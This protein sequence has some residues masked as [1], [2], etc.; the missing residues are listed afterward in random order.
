[1]RLLLSCLLFALTLSLSAQQTNVVWKLTKEDDRLK[2]YTAES[3]E[4][5]LVKIEM[6]VAASVDKIMMFVSDADSY[7]TWIHRCESA[8]RLKTVSATQYYYYS[9]INLPIPFSDRD[10]VALVKEK[11]D[12]ATGSVQRSIV[13][14]PGYIPE[15]KGIQRI[16]QYDS[17]WRLTPLPSGLTYVE[18]IVESD[19]GSGLP[20]WLRT[21]I[22][23]GAPA[24]T[25]HNL[26]ALAEK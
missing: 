8:K 5:I 10:V 18:C 16:K 23:T 2:I 15:N 13:A 4:N 1:M 9:H 17:S 20:G 3:G 6:N 11:K 7:A 24:K 22:M 21:Q 12:P 26:A 19:A 14:V 25:M